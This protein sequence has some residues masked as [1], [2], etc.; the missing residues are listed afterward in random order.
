MRI[1][2]SRAATERQPRQIGVAML[3]DC[4]TR[5]A[6]QELMVVPPKNGPGMKKGNEW[7]A[8]ARERERG[9]RLGLLCMAREGRIAIPMWDWPGLE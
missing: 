5:A 2:S 9:K 1:G 6:H 3:L 8:R 7:I 4:Y